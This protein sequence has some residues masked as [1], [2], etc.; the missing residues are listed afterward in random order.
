LGLTKYIALI[1]DSDRFA[2]KIAEPI[3]RGISKMTFDTRNHIDH[4]SY[5]LQS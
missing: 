3:E 2:I 5:T 1:G 4:Y